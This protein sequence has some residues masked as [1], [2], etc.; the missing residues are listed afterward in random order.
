MFEEDDSDSFQTASEVD[1]DDEKPESRH[2]DDGSSDGADLFDSDEEKELSKKFKRPEKSE[3]S[4]IGIDWGDDSGKDS[5]S[6][7]GSDE[8]ASE[9]DDH[10]NRNIGRPDVKSCPGDDK[11]A[12]LENYLTIQLRRDVLERYV[13]EPYFEAAVLNNYVRVLVGTQN[14]ILVYRMGLVV[15]VEQEGRKY[16]NAKK[17]MCTN[18]RLVVDIAGNTKKMKIRDIS[19]SRL[20]PGAGDLV[21]FSIIFDV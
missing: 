19:N 3:Q 15:G 6:D 20:T 18:K 12:G 21:R 11:E 1:S 16:W 14:G 7:G 17:T 4:A 5:D 10:V 9:A 8:K 13:R 2:S